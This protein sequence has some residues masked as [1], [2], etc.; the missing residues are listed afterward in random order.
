MEHV[1]PNVR[2]LPSD[3]PDV[4]IRVNACP[5]ETEPATLS[6][7][8]L[9]SILS[10]TLTVTEPLQGP[11]G[12]SI[13]SSAFTVYHLRF[14][15]KRTT[16]QSKAFYRQIPM[17]LDRAASF[18]VPADTAHSFWLDIAVPEGTPAGVYNG[19]VHVKLD[20][21]TQDI[22]VAVTVRPFTLP[23]VTKQFFGEYYTTPQ[24]FSKTELPKVIDGDFA[25]MRSLG[26]TS[27]GLCIS[28]DPTP[29]K[30]ADGKVTIAFKDNDP[31]VYAMNAYVKY[32]Y[33]CPVILLSDPGYSYAQNNGGHDNEE[34]LKIVHRAY[35]TAMQEECRKRGWPELIIQPV[36]EPSWQS[37]D[38]M[39]RNVKMLKMLKSVPGL[40]TEQDGPADN[41]FINVAQG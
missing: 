14:L 27:V 29:C 9:K 23:N 11:N 1:F 38:S 31:F 2:P 3:S 35:W 12:A 4:S 21:A 28:P 6:L 16:Y 24:G 7:F 41:Y 33:P 13:P 15:D 37:Q 39:D 17:V 40:R 5:G 19:R 26:M 25:Y 22:P 34:L 20:D 30:Y 10:A 32:K 36:D 8:A 18:P